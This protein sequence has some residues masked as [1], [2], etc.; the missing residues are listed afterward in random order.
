MQWRKTRLFRAGDWG[1][2]RETFVELRNA[3]GV[4]GSVFYR[5]GGE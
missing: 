1:N 3:L 2:G 4:S 5:T